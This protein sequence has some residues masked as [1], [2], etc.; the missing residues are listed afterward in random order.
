MPET[1]VAKSVRSSPQVRWSRFRTIALSLRIR[2]M[3]QIKRASACSYTK[4]SSRST[5]NAAMEIRPRAVS[6]SM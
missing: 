1:V 5:A 6:L 2:G 4:R 3:P